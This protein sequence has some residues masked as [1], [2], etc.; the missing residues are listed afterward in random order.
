VTPPPDLEGL[1]DKLIRDVPDY[2]QPGVLFK[3]ITPLLA[4]H[5][6]FTAVVEALAAT[7]RDA[8]G[9]PVVDKVVGMEAR[10]F[11]LAAPVALALGAGF[12]PVRKAGKLPRETYA[13]SYALEYGHA[14]I[15]VHQDGIGSGERVLIVDDV[16]ATGG[17]ADATRQLV[18]RCGGV[19]HALSVLIELSFLHGRDSIGDLELHALTTV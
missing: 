9:D 18:E 10:G 1:L 3:D 7:G 5:D 11:I 2:P 16:L 4:D 14:T 8:D 19:P 12:V 17:T 15:E 13:V 6:G